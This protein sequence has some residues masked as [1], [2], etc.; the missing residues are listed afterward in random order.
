MRL[1]KRSVASALALAVVRIAFPS[2]LGST[3]CRADSPVNCTVNFNLAAGASLGALQFR[4]NYSSTTGDI[5]GS[6]GSA[7]CTNDVP[8]ALRSLNDDDG[9]KT[10]HWGDMSAGGFQGPQSLGQCLFQAST[11]P[12]PSNFVITGDDSATTVS[13]T[14]NSTH[15]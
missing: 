4:T 13:V 12:I 14:G 3:D 6:A 10:L 11:V 9:A 8:A 15:V 1:V 2:I 5:V 7:A